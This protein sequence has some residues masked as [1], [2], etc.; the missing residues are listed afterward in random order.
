[1][2]TPATVSGAHRSAAALRGQIVLLRSERS[3]EAL[4][5]SLYRSQKYSVEDMLLFESLILLPVLGWF[6]R[7]RLPSRRRK[8][9]S[10]VEG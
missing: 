5:S 2:P 7:I 10:G 1:M 4:R 9:R 3:Y 6:S 8:V